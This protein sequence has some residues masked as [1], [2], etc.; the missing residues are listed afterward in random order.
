MRKTILGFIAVVPM[1]LIT[2]SCG[3][4]NTPTSVAEK[5]LEYIQD[6]NYEGYVDLIQIE[7]KE[8]QNI[9]EQKAQLTALISEKL[10]KTFDKK[11][12]IKS[13]EIVSEELSED[14]NKATV[15]VNITF[16]DD[17]TEEQKLKTIKDADGNWK[18]D[19]GK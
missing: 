17:S 18:L 8:G 7:E 6:K 12:G 1:M 13:W 4:A 2:W 16:G 15:K 14:G 5:A 9:E 19:A 3:T 11:Q 10:G